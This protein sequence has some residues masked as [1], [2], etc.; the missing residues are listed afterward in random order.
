MEHLPQFFDSSSYGQPAS[1]KNFQ[2][3]LQEQDASEWVKMIRRGISWQQ[4][5]SW[6]ANADIPRKTLAESL[7][8]PVRTLSRRQKEG[9]LSPEESNKFLRFMKAVSRGEDVFG[10]THRALEWLLKPN[11]SMNGDTPIS[12]LDTDIGTELVFDTLGRI[13]HG[14]FS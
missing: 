4:M 2:C 9:V 1:A 10:N 12:L 11:R 5:E 14:V 3:I 13:E 7:A 8:I 6:L